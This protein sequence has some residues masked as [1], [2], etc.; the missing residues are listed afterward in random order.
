MGLGR[1]QGIEEMK[2]LVEGGD[3]PV[4]ENCTTCYAC[5]EYC[6]TGAMPFDLV[7]AL[8]GER[9]SLKLSKG[10]LQ[11][12]EK[13]YEPY[14][15]SKTAK[16]PPDGRVLSQCA[17]LRTHAA[18][19]EGRPWEGLAKV[20]GRNFFC[21]M[22]YLH[23]GQIDVV[24]KR[25]RTIV[26]NFE[27]LGAKEVVCFHDECYAFFTT[28]APAFG[29]EVPFRVKHASMHLVEYLKAH[30]DD[31]EPLGLRAAYQRSCSSRLTP[32]KDRCLDELF[33][34]VGVERVERKYDGRNAL[35]CQAPT[36]QLSSAVDRRL[37]SREEVKR[38]RADA[39]A[40]QQANVRDALE[41]G[42]TAM[43]FVCPTCLDTLGKTCEGAGL[44]PIFFTE[45]A[46]MALGELEATT[47]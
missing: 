23:T 46:R 16:L 22:V 18:F 45:L 6:P 43:V 9:N 29:V 26:E 5:N 12:L 38:K 31:I 3:S 11:V 40:R 36:L 1:E 13:Q 15:S 20:G 10:A 30:E 14:E 28:Y 44:Q 25:A 32:Q 24:E 19:F 37:A 4:L 47:R 41:A 17:F 8:Q 35:C 21:N 7:A 33:R 2:K 39:R 34:L 27:R 42:A